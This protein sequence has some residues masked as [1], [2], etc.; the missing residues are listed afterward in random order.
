MSKY[1]SNLKSW[2]MPVFI[3][4]IFSLSASAAAQ[5][6]TLDRDLDK[7]VIPGKQLK[8]VKGKPIADLRLMVF[9]DG[10][11]APIPFQVDERQANGDFVMKR[12]DGSMDQDGDK[13]KLDN[14]DEL[15]FMASDS[16]DKGDPAASGPP[17]SAW[18]EITLR[19]PKSG[20]LGWAYLLAFDKNAPALS[21]VRYMQYNQKPEYDEL[22]TPH[23]TLRF[24]NGNVFFHDLM[25]HESAGGNNKDLMDRIKMRSG[26]DVLGGW[27]SITRTEEDFVHEVLGVI[28]GP[29]RVI[30]QTD[31]RLVLL[32]SLKSPSAIVDGSFYPTCFEFPSMLSLPFRMDIFASGA[33]LRQGWD[34]NKTAKG[35]KLYT[36]VNREGVTMDGKMS[37]AETTMAS[38]QDTLRWALG[39]GKQ[40]SF[41]FFGTWDSGSPLKALLYY[42]DDLTRLEPPE[43]DPGVMG[44]AYK[45]VN[46]HE[47]GGEE[48]PF[49]ITNYVLPNYDGDIDRVL[50][51][52]DHPLEVSVNK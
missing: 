42:E 6:L 23:Y 8:K 40:G 37:P 33:Y 50:R 7:V 18:S 17:C 49:N 32:L 13:G 24:P 14:N 34:L 45:L 5:T 16:G 3:M 9:K 29:V 19:D 20:D 1:F 38:S 43:D 4:L 31:T 21:P 39:T 44:F 12:A 47:M 28:E 35:L 41:V 48:Y 22:I 11:L 52:L 25:I 46:L 26:V 27:V 30:R 2:V 10:S 51:V 15:V 36:S